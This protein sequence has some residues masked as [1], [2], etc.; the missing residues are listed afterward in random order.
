MRN[1]Y[2]T[3]WVGSWSTWFLAHEM[4]LAIFSSPSIVL[5]H[6]LAD[7]SKPAFTD[8]EQWTESTTGQWLAPQYKDQECLTGVT[9]IGK[10]VCSHV[11]QTV[12]LFKFELIFSSNMFLVSW[13]CFLLLGLNYTTSHFLCCQFWTTEIIRLLSYCD[14]LWID[15][16]HPHCDT[17]W[18]RKQCLIASSACPF[19]SVLSSLTDD[20]A[21]QYFFR[22][23]AGGVTL[24]SFYKREFWQL[25]WRSASLCRRRLKVEGEGRVVICR[26]SVNTLQAE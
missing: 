22:S 11:T 6:C 17:Q 10:A 16:S 20:W 24:R 7:V 2:Q 14:M 13:I 12:F 3:I 21:L 23:Q 1:W 19:L 26:C 5:M 25:W 18:A 4:E 15:G 8:P 9:E